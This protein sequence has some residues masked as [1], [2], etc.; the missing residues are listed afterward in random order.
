MKKNVMS[1][2]YGNITPDYLET[3]ARVL[4]NL[5]EVQLKLGDPASGPQVQDN[6]KSMLNKANT[7]KWI[8]DIQGGGAES[9]LSQYNSK[10]EPVAANVAVMDRH[11]RYVSV[12]TSLNTWFGSKIMSSDGVLLSNAMANFATDNEAEGVTSNLMARGQR[13]LSSNVVALSMDT[14]NICGTRI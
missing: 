12:V 14:K 1:T 2:D 3:V 6:V 11:D 10:S 13:P 4:K 7:A 8:S 5:E 9:I